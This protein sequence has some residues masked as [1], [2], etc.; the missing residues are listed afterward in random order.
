VSYIQVLLLLGI[1]LLFI[2]YFRILRSSASD[3]AVF[4]VFCLMGVIAISHPEYSTTIAHALGVG[5]GTDL[6]LYG[7][8]IFS[9]FVSLVLYTRQK[10]LQITLTQL[11][12][13]IAKKK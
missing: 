10:A 7:F 4:V 3:R 8:I 13:E 6:L 2:G 9:S 12:R 1:F 11:T 5:R